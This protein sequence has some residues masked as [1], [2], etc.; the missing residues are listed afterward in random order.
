[1]KALNLSLADELQVIIDNMM[2]LEVL[3]QSADLTGNVTLRNIATTHADTT[4]KN[5]IRT[6]GQ[7]GTA[8]YEHL[9]WD[10]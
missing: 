4:M 7:S 8:F 9:F 6:D 1:L 2:N 3:F 5:H 10:R